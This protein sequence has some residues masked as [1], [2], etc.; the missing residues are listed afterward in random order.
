ML[1][2]LKFVA[3]PVVKHQNPIHRRRFKLAER[4]KEQKELL[5]NPNYQTVRQRWIKSDNG[6]KELVTKARRVKRWWMVDITGL[7]ILTLRYGNK[8][9]E[10]NKGKP[11]IA[12]ENAT[13]LDRIFDLVIQA[14]NAG[15]LDKHLVL[16]D[17]DDIKR[18]PKKAA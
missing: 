7:Y 13:D 1:E 5:A 18:K 2:Q 17:F 12:C 11:S 16:P 3:L 6:S 9:I 4:L 14:V 10:I 15:E 8:V